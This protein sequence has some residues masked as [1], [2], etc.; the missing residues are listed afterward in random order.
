MFK[1]VCLSVFLEVCEQR[2]IILI[3]IEFIFTEE[4][5]RNS[6]KKNYITSEY[7]IIAPIFN[8]FR[9]IFIFNQ[10]IK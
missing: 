9:C 7:R 6:I 4:A 5:K 1:S 3:F 8:C 2:N 10:K